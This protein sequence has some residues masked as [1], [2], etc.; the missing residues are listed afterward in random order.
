MWSKT[1][2]DGPPSTATAQA[3]LTVM[4]TTCALLVAGPF[5]DAVLPPDYTGA[6]GLYPWI[7]IGMLFFGLYLIPMDALAL[8]SGRTRWIW[9]I[10]G[11]AAI[12]NVALNV[13][14]VPRYG[15]L[16]CAIATAVAYAILLAGVYAYARRTTPDETRYEWRPFALSARG[17]IIA[18]VTVAIV[19]LPIAE[20]RLAP[21]TN[22][23]C[24]G[25]RVGHHR[26]DTPSW[27][28]DTPNQTAMTTVFVVIRCLNEAAHIERLLVGLS[29]QTVKPD[30]IIVVESGSTDSTLSIAQRHVVEVHTCM[31]VPAAAS[32]MISRRVV[33]RSHG[34]RHSVGSGR[35]LRSQ[36]R[37]LL[38]RPHAV[39]N[40]HGADAC[41]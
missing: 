25:H 28:A 7:A 36:P 23:G 12:S 19:T 24:I 26:G 27:P 1:E 39:R 21:G 13:Y 32:P 4:L 38:G 16:A 29:E 30:Q 34:V 35:L 37:S 10:T 2:T 31:S 33:T 20:A 22:R 11:A 9:L 40:H 3:I 8:S 41:G 15:S 14:L 17:I 5:I 6:V 18:G